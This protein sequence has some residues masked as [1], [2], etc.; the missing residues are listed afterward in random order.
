MGVASSAQCWPVGLVLGGGVAGALAAGGAV[1]CALPGSSVIPVAM[2]MMP[3]I[4]TAN[5]MKRL[6]S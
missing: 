1:R 3:M 2:A 5:H 4:A 6:P